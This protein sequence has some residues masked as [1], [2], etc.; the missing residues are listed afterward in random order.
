MCSPLYTHV[1]ERIVPK[2]LCPI[3]WVKKS[4]FSPTPAHDVPCC[5]RLP[6]EEALQT[7]RSTAA[8][9]ICTS[10]CISRTTQGRLATSRCLQIPEHFLL[11]M[12]LP[13]DSRHQAMGWLWGLTG[14][15]G[16][17]GT[18]LAIICRGH[19][20]LA[21]PVSIISIG[22]MCISNS[23]LGRNCL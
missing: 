21:H 6:R 10:S 5:P 9:S 17:P 23:F 20:P 2:L 14:D 15:P 12:V 19:I 13:S 3:T 22:V 16:K 11:P 8:C 7:Y 1:V 4:G 18:H